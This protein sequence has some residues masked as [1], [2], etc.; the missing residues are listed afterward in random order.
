[1]INSLDRPK[2]ANRGSAKR[3]VPKCQYCGS[4]AEQ[5]NGTRIYGRN[6][7]KTF[8]V[9]EKYP[10]CDAYVGCYPHGSGMKPLGSL[11]NLELRTWRKRAHAVFDPLWREDISKSGTSKGVARRKAY[12]WLAKSLGIEI[13]DC[14]I[15]HFD[16]AACQ[17]VVELCA[18]TD[19]KY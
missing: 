18:A 1:M 12:A 17:R 4:R 3:R 5:D 9:C 2:M 16:I 6:M 14:H 11:A 10:E 19:A 8:W 15:G 7:S 13:D